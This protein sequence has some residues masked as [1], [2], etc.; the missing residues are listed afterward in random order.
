LHYLFKG[1][2]NYWNPLK[3][4]SKKR[5]R[6]RRKRADW[7]RMSE[8]KKGGKNTGNERGRREESSRPLCVLSQTKS[9]GI[10]IG[11]FA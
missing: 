4:V 5:E 6:A 8:R 2:R 3:P 9:E 1:Q 10:G 7:V 11:R